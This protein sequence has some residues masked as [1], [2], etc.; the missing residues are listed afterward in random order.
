MKVAI[1]NVGNELLDGSTINTNDHYLSSRLTVIGCHVKDIRVVG[2]NSLSIA[3]A[4]KDLINNVDVIITTGGLGPTADDITKESIAKA[5]GLKLI[6]NHKIESDLELFFKSRNLQMTSNNKRQAYCIEGSEILKNNCGTAPGSK[7]I[8]ESTAIYILPGPPKELAMM[9]EELVENELI[10]LVN[11]KKFA[12]KF[13]CIGIGESSLETL[14]YDIITECKLS[15]RI[16]A[17]NGLVDV[18]IGSYD[19]I[20]FRESCE[21][22]TEILDDYCY[23]NS[24]SIQEVV[25]D[26][27]ESKNWTIGFAESCTAGMCSSMFA[28]ISGVSSVYKGS[29]VSYSNE[30]KINNLN[31]AKHTIEKYGAVS[32]ECAIEMVNGVVNSLDVDVA[33]SITGIAGPTGG[34]KI[35]PVGL[36]Y[37]ATNVKGM[38]EVKEYNISGDRETVRRR[39]CNFAFNQLNKNI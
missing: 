30:I 24:K 25:A 5:L 6:Y 39:A 38:V 11:D 4:I 22:I 3:S 1:I 8:Y 12:M 37:I 21:K 15:Y 2:D 27:L 26:K 17:N 14:I 35:K 34:S 29:V 33:V 10:N 9:Y 19:E 13:K 23:S 16:C 32:R 20:S 31:V 7:L 36:V 18:D 28:D